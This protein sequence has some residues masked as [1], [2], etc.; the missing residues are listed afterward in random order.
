MESYT[1]KPTSRKF[2]HQFN[3]TPVIP[4]GISLDWTQE[5]SFTFNLCIFLW[6]FTNICVSFLVHFGIVISPVDVWFLS[7]KFVYLTV[8]LVSEDRLLLRSYYDF[9]TIQWGRH[10]KT[11]EENEKIIFFSGQT[12]CPPGQFVLHLGTPLHRRHSMLR[13][14]SS[15]TERR[16]ESKRLNRNG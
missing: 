4:S 16:V 6:L 14:V 12:D 10:H 7:E 2:P 9:K 8:E 13:Y 3:F 15:T 1:D 11:I 5:S